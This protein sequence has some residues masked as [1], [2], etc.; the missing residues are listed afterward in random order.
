[1]R[2]AVVSGKSRAVDGEGHREALQADVV[3]DLIV[4]SLEKR[5]IDA[6]DGAHSLRGETRGE[7]DRMLLG[8]SDIEKA[9]RI[10]HLELDERSS[11]RHRRGDGDDPWIVPSELDYGLSEDVLVFRRRWGR[12]RR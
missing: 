3:D 7:G 4:G 8:D 12:S 5:R 2:A 6:D 11:G 9:I 1:M 10:G